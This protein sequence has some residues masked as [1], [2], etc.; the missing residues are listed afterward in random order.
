MERWKDKILKDGK[1]G[2]TIEMEGQTE[3]WNNRTIKKIMDEQID[4][5]GTMV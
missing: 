1:I 2:R 3:Q 5:N 4:K